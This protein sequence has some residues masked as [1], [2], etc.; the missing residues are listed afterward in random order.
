M[1]T[2][3][4][5]V[6]T[7]NASY[8]RAVREEQRKTREA[9]KLQQENLKQQIKNNNIAAIRNY[10]E[11]IESLLSIHKECSESLNWECYAT[12]PE[13]KL[14]V[15][16]SAKQDEA[17]YHYKIYKPSILDIVLVQNKKKLKDLFNKIELAKQADDR[18]YNAVLKEFKNNVDD[19]KKIQDI[20]KGISEADPLAYKN[21]ID[22]FDP[23]S[24]IS[25]LGTQLG[26]EVFSDHITVNMYVNAE[27]VIPNYVL[28]QTPSGR[29]S[30]KK[31]TVSKFNEIYRD[32][33]CGCALRVARETFAL[34][35]VR[36][37]FLNTF[38]GISNNG[39]GQVE[40]KAI[41]SVR[42]DP[43]NLKAL[44][45]DTE[46]CHDAL[47]KFPRHMKFTKAHGFSGIEILK[48]GVDLSPRK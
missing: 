1:T 12:E 26:C 47:I 17:E 4:S 13:P 34:L 8:K 45:F 11:Y 10:N 30:N 44:N 2:V 9:A 16:Q 20:T 33:V 6:R 19:W 23:F 15:R 24:Q 14:P 18:I 35:P 43:Y 32:Y 5:Q 38:A 3:K 27:E 21:A 29:L 48:D 22:F 25:H 31:L 42:F 36:F 46:S 40:S 7:A 39:T 37:V 41:L 28:S